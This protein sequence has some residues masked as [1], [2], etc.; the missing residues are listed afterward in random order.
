MGDK[1]SAETYHTEHIKVHL[2]PVHPN[3][4]GYVTSIHLTEAR[5]EKAQQREQLCPG[6]SA[7]SWPFGQD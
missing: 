7:L 2:P 5:H 3:N 6:E 1:S 4:T